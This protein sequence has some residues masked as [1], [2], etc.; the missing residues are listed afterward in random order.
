MED[1]GRGGIASQ[2]RGRWGAA[3]QRDE[4]HA[5]N[6]AR[7]ALILACARHGRLHAGSASNDDVRPSIGRRHETTEAPAGASFP[8]VSGFPS[9]NVVRLGLAS[10]I[11]PLGRPERLGVRTLAPCGCPGSQSCRD[12]AG[13]IARAY[14]A[15]LRR[16]S[17]SIGS[18]KRR[19]G[20][21]SVPPHIGQYSG[22]TRVATPYPQVEHCASAVRPRA[23]GVYSASV[24]MLSGKPRTASAMRRP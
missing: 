9:G 24:L 1:P 8:L 14:A 20:A 18:R 3:A 15:S 23:V 4:Q 2:G 16:R 12:G 11:L 5:K 22:G 7:H 19:C 13:N 10:H 17:S 21:H 6:P